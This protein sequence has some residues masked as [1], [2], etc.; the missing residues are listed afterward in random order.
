M[1]AISNEKRKSLKKQMVQLLDQFLLGYISAKDL[2]HAAVPMLTLSA[3]KRGRKNYIEKYLME[4]AGKSDKD[5][6]RDYVYRLRETITGDVITS[7][8][9]RAKIFKRSLRKLIERLVYEEIDSSYFVTTLY[10]LMFDYDAEAN[11]EKEIKSFFEK[12]QKLTTYPSDSE[13]SISSEASAQS[14]LQVS[15]E[16]YE[17]YYK[18]LWDE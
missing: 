10:E 6:S 12:I 2:K 4:I 7:E 3:N 8:K 9:D 16:F 18:G 13:A 11:A 15:L 5:L 1:R 17:A 14:I